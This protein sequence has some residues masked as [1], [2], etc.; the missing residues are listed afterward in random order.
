M[1][2]DEVAFFS[3]DFVDYHK[4]YDNITNDSSNGLF[5]KSVNKCPNRKS[6]VD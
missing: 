3:V 1:K 6:K 4:Q 2:G 5:S